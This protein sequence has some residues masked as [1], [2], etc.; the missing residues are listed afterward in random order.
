MALFRSSRFV[1]TLASLFLFASCSS[2][3]GGGSS[4]N[5]DGSSNGG[6][7]G[8]DQGQASG[9]V[10]QPSSATLFSPAITDVSIEI[11]Y[12]KDAAPYTGSAGTTS[13]VFTIMGDN[14]ARIFQNAPKHVTIPSTLDQMQELD[15]V[16]A[17]SFTNDA[18]L[19]IA[20]AHRDQKNTASTATFYIVF[21]NGYYDQGQG[22]D[23][24]I[25]GVSL[26]DTG[27][28]AMFKPVIAGTQSTLP[29]TP[30]YVEQ[31]TLVHEFGHAV[32]LVN[33]GITM[34]TPHQDSAHGAHC[35]NTKCTMY[36]E[37][38]GASAATQFALDHFLGGSDILFGDECLADLDGQA[39]AS[40]K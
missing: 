40:K 33:N 39:T 11:D 38:E 4:E 9:S 21:V 17:T 29:G 34:T 35:T 13:D 30:Q 6:G 20:T 16:T 18:I 19:A 31:S 14:V 10:G 24:G 22:P 28:I 15:D 27:V 25:I 36:W 12:A 37:N 23:H 7:G 3:S 26:G 2:S 32:G 8:S 1:W 5:G